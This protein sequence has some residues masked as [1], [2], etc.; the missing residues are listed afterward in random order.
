MTR[1]DPP[2]LCFSVWLDSTAVSCHFFFL[3]EFP[4]QLPSPNGQ[5]ECG[6]ISM[7]LDAYC[8]SHDSSEPV[9]AVQ[10]I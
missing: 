5:V 8:F 6:L 10:M 4:W 2:A 3:I 9:T 1:E 7:A